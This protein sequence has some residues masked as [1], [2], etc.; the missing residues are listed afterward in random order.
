[1]DLA[2]ANGQR[3]LVDDVPVGR[4]PSAHDG[5]AEPERA[6]DH[7]VIRCA[8]RRVD[9]EHHACAID[10]ELA[11]YDDCDVHVRLSE[12]ALCPVEDRARAEQGRP[13]ATHRLDD[14]VGATDVQVGLVHSGERGGLCV[15]GRG[16]RTHGDAGI[17]A[18]LGVG[19]PKF[20]LDG[21]GDRGG[22]N[23]RAHLVGGATERLCVIHVEAGESF[24]DAVA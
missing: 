19:L 10:V 6:L 4:H 20:G 18:E 1:M 24:R 12:P 17:G 23:H 3:L 13:A 15:L 11:L 14:G 9:R 8:R 7:D 22:G 21:F 2:R 5:L 16:R